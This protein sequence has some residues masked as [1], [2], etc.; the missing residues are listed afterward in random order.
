MSDDCL[1]ESVVSSRLASNKNGSKASIRT[2]RRTL[3][4]QQGSLPSLEG[5]G[6]SVSVL[7]LEGLNVKKVTGLTHRRFLTAIQRFTRIRVP[8]LSTRKQA[9]SAVRLRFYK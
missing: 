9:S 2:W 1:L 5:K 3:A 7:R 4:G 8:L 6:S